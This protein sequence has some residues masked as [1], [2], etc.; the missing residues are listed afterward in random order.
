MFMMTKNNEL[1]RWGEQLV[2]DKL[3]AEGYA[4][5]ARNWHMNQYEIDLI[6]INEGEIAF[7][8]VKTREDDDGGD[9]LDAITP[10]K[11]RHMVASANVFLDTLDLRRSPRFDVCGITGTPDTGYKME[12]IEDA[13]R[14]PLK[15]YR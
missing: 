9:P 10:K 12:Y 2:C 4:I 13:F 3:T 6:A 5:V 7:I 8:E 15:S 11:I 14:P 1:G